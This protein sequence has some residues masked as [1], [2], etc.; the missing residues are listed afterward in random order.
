MRFGDA[1]VSSTRAARVAP[2]VTATQA[3]AVEE[4]DIIKQML[5]KQQLKSVKELAQVRARY[6]NAIE[7]KA[8]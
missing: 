4:A 2:K 5:Q 1:Q 6:T 3:A 8:P 7:C